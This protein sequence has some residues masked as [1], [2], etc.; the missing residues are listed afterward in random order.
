MARRRS[1]TDFSRL[2]VGGGETLGEETPTDV[3][4]VVEGKDSWPARKAGNISKHGEEMKSLI[5]VAIACFALCPAT[6]QDSDGFEAYFKE[7]KQAVR[8]NDQQK[9]LSM[10]ELSRFRWEDGFGDI[11]T[12]EEF[13]KAY[14]KMFTPLVKARIAGGRPNKTD[15]GNYILVWNRGNNEYS[16]AFDRINGTFKFSGMYV[17]PR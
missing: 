16:L 7:F 9:V 8:S 12:K 6:P 1:N 15:E 2:R 11:R 13:L 4:S 14:A 10:C 5:L 17:G 3:F